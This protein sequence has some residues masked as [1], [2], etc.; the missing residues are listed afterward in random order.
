MRFLSVLYLIFENFHPFGLLFS[1]KTPQTIP[2]KNHNLLI[3]YA[4]RVQR[5]KAR[6]ALNMQSR[7][8]N[9]TI[10]NI[11]LWA[12]CSW[13]CLCIYWKCFFFFGRRNTLKDNTV[14]NELINHPTN[15]MPRRIYL[16]D[17]KPIR[18]F[19]IARFELPDL[20]NTILITH[21]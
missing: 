1:D 8:N 10:F 12:I 9:E 7:E 16:N 6:V 3:F 4:L 21:S 13:I 19:F 20:I 17:I 18:I 5:R 2:K 11:H 14:N 15:E